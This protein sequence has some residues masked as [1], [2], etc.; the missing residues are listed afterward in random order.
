MA[1]LGQTNGP[2]KA[3]F[4]HRT[5]KAIDLKVVFDMN[6]SIFVNCTCV[7]MCEY[8][9]MCVVHF[10]LLT[11]TLAVTSVTFLSTFNVFSSLVLAVLPVPP[12]LSLF[13]SHTLSVL[14][15]TPQAA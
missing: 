1:T 9:R 8:L 7:K 3:A 6:A 10:L 11:I 4:F 2:G 15:F 5:P 14:V 13:F 12:P